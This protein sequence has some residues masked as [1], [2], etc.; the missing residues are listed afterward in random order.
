MLDWGPI[1]LQAPDLGTVNPAAVVIAAAAS[2]LIFTFRLSALRTIGV[3]AALGLA[4]GLI[5]IP[6]G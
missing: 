5:G 4:A 1:H 6:L 3:C 2:L